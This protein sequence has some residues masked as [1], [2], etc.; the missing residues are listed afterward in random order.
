MLLEDEEAARPALRAL[1]RALDELFPP[2]PAILEE[3]LDIPTTW[4]PEGVTEEDIRAL[5]ELSTVHVVDGAQVR[6]LMLEVLRRAAHDWVLYRGSRRKEFREL[7]HDAYTWLFEEEQGHPWFEARKLGG[8]TLMSLVSICEVM[9]IDIDAVRD[10]VRKMT[11]E[12][13]K[14]AGRPPERRKKQTEDSS[15]YSEHSVFA[16]Y[17]CGDSDGD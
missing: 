12:K 2:P 14:T 1:G 10:R 4:E 6:V 13:I 11:A 8:T 3:T 16:T 7:A 9:D 5:E 17:S 15:Y